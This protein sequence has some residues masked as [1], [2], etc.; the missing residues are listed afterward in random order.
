[1]FLTI[2]LVFFGKGNYF[3]K[4]TKKKLP[5]KNKEMRTTPQ[6]GADGIRKNAN[7]L[8]RFAFFKELREL[9]EFRSYR[10]MLFSSL[11]P[12]SSFL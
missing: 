12:R 10:Q 9:Q 7:L 4:I 5:K 8:E 2:T 3:L 1:M 11:A 6:F